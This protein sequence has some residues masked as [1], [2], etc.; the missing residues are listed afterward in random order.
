MTEL[1]LLIILLASLVG[2][3]VILYRKMPALAKL[4]ETSDSLP[5]LSEII[6]KAKEKTKEEAKKL[7]GVGKFDH[8][9][10]L[11]KILSKIRILTLKTENKTGIWLEKLRSK[12]NSPDKDDYWQELKR[13]KNGKKPG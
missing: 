1:I 11:Q 3:G 7:P 5:P 8:E 4:P 12:R 13:A 2:M 10:Y 9:L 6:Q